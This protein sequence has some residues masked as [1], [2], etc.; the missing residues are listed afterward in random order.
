[1]DKRIE[2]GHWVTSIKNLHPWE[3]NPRDV[4]ED[5]FERLKEQIVDL[6][7][8]KTILVT[9]NGTIIGGNTRYRALSWL[10]E[11]VYVRT[12][13]DGTP[14]EYDLRGQ[15]NDVWI[16]ELDFEYMPAVDGQM[17]SVYPTIDGVRQ[18]HTRSFSSAEQIMIEYALSDNDNVGR[19]NN[20]AVAMLVQ[21]FQELIPQDMYKIEVA[22]P[23][24][25]QSLLNDFQ[26]DGTNPTEEELPEPKEAK[27]KKKRIVFEFEDEQMYDQVKG[28]I[29]DLKKDQ[30]V[31][32]EAAVLDYL[33]KSYFDPLAIDGME[34]PKQEG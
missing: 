26:P 16:S 1:M 18:S 15:F 13:P 9:G 2:N 5:D 17:A 10:N 22:N 25:L 33:L 11:N 32:S 19:Y 21:P 12:L 6:G 8:Y 34:A 3:K 29:E 28:Q 23:I 24:P 20:Q 31:E 30:G 14:K 27:E 4:Y 7:I